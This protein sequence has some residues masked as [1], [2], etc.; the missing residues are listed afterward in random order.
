MLMAVKGMRRLTGLGAAVAVAL[1]VGTARAAVAGGGAVALG[2]TAP[3]ADGLLPAQAAMVSR[4]AANTARPANQRAPRPDTPVDMVP[5][6][7]RLTLGS[8][9]TSL[10]GLEARPPLLAV[11]PEL[12]DGVVGEAGVEHLRQRRR[13][14]DGAL[15]HQPVE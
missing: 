2:A 10:P 7:R 6:P 3:G 9:K 12:L 8:M 13:L 11:G 5:S 14:R 4:N 1:A 15:L